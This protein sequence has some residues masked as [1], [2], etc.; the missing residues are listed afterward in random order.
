M[1]IDA[2]VLPLRHLHCTLLVTLALIALSPSLARAQA[3]Y[4]SIGGTITDSSGAVLPGATVTIT[5]V[6]R[7]TPDSVVTNQSGFYVK[8]R[9]VPGKYEVKAE[10][11]GFKSAVF[12]DVNV[13][14]DTQTQLNVKLDVG[15]VTENVT[16]AGF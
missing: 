14:V 16:V 6:E 3:V 15:N 1:M 11:P 4:G 7:K 2:P 8:E 9:L 12:P 5:S 10:L 13:S